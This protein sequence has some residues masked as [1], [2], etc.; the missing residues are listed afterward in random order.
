MTRELPVKLNPI[1]P[2]DVNTYVKEGGAA[3][4][5]PDED[6]A[7]PLY[8]AC[9]EATPARPLSSSRAART[10]TVRRHVR[11]CT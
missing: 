8:C 7:T 6:G 11:M 4:D 1:V 5:Q 9:Q 3:L 2:Q 10:S